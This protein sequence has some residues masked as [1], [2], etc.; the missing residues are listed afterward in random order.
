MSGT[1][2]AAVRVLA[3]AGIESG[4]GVGAGTEDTVV[5]AVAAG[6][7]VSTSPNEVSAGATSIVTI[8]RSQ[9]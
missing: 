5:I 7:A 1:E 3:P 8:A 9:E 2:F 6:I 4:A